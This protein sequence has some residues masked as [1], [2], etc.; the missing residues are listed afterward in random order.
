MSYTHSLK[1]EDEPALG[2]GLKIA[3]TDHRGWFRGVDE[4]SAKSSSARYEG[5]RES[6]GR[7]VFHYISGHDFRGQGSRTLALS[8]TIATVE[9]E[10]TE[11]RRP[12]RRPGV[13]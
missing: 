10:N 7:E 5:W 6:P 2:G 13:V 4:G 9:F 1:C 11:P 3:C 12:I 8:L